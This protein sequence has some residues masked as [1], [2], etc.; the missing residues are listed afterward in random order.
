MNT[1]I[2]RSAQLRSA[3]SI[4]VTGNGKTIGVLEVFAEQPNAFDEQ[5][6][7]LLHAF[8]ELLTELITA[9]TASGN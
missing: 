1:S 7:S 3:A 8:S 6:Y 2:W 9:A 4:P 5:D